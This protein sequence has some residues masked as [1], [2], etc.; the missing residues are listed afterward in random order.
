MPG[1]ILG[2][3]NVTLTKNSLEYLPSLMAAS[4]RHRSHFLP[5]SFSDMLNISLCQA[6]SVK[7]I[8]SD[9]FKAIG[10]AS[11]DID[12]SERFDFNALGL[13]TP[14]HDKSYVNI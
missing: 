13:L 1:L 3:F 2:H 11:T 9:A 7:P 14:L 6:K 4:A 10:K 5:S 12:Q 8:S